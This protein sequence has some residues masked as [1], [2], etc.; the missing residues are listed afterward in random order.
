MIERL[1]GLPGPGTKLLN[2]GLSRRFRDTWSLWYR[3]MLNYLNYYIMICTISGDRPY[4]NSSMAVYGCLVTTCA[5]SCSYM[6]IFI[7]IISL[8]ILPK[9]CTLACID[10]LRAFKLYWKAHV[11]PWLNET[12]KVSISRES[13]K[14]VK[15]FC[16]QRL[17]RGREHPCG[18]L[19][20]H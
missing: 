17:F 1:K 7:H 8:S 2:P 11:S 4:V 20:R 16:R 10:T 3:L 18:G 5:H 14:K 12:L 6:R 15:F 19:L 9:L 13:L